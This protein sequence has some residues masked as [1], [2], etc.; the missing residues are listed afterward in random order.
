M[1]ALPSDAI[2]FFGATG[3]LAYKQIFPSLLGLVRDEGLNVPIIGVAKAGWNLDQLK[4]RAADSLQHHGGGGSGRRMQRL[5]GLLRYVDGDYN[6]PA[7]FAELRKQLGEAQRPLHYLAV[8]PSLFA[9][10]AEALAKSGCAEQR[11]AGG[12]EAV[13]PQ[14]RDGAHAE[15][16]AGAVLS[17]GEHLPHRPLPRQGAGAEHRLYALRQLDVR[18]AVEPRPCQ[19]HPDHH[20]GGFRRPGSRPLLRRDRRDPR[21]GAEPHAA[22]ARATDDGPADRR[23]ARGDARPEGGAAEGGASARSE[24]RGARAVCGLSV[25][26]GRAR[27]LDRRNLR[28]RRSCSSTP[29]DGPACRSISAPARSCR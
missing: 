5:I 28:R 8:P 24:A 23:G 12:R 29:G 4:A 26:A 21:R 3:D 9:T 15:P 14:P 6:D 27:G 19:Q 16:P 25:G 22:G 20:G 1:A 10:V 17:R 11:P 2:V 7:T 18:A 13:R